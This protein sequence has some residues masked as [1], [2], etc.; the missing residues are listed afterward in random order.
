[1]YRDIPLYRMDTA[2]AMA[3]TLEEFRLFDFWFQHII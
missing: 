1:M 2:D 3:M